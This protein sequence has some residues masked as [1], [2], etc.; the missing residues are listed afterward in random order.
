MLRFLDKFD[1]FNPI[2][3]ISANISLNSF[4]P[5]LSLLSFWNSNYIYDCPLDTHRSQNFVH[6]FINLSLDNLYWLISKFTDY[7][8]SVANA[9]IPIQLMLILDIVVL[10]FRIFIWFKRLYIFLKFPQVLLQFIFHFSYRFFNICAIITL[11]SVYVNSTIW[12]IC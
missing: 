12:I 7:S 1:I 2:W 11:K 3:K 8:S 10:S 5:T 9:D 4:S 6:F